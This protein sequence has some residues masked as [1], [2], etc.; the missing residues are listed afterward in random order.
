MRPM[1][2]D[3][4]LNSIATTASAI[5][6][7]ASA[8]MMC[9]PRISS[10][11]ASAIILTKPSALPMPSARPFAIIGNWPVLISRPSAFSCCSVLP[12]HAISGSV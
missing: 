3:A 6:S 8:A 9:T 12:T 5:R 10:V 1:S 11:F 7:D 2:S 4:A